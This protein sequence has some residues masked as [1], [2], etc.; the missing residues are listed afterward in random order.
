[1]LQGVY[2]YDRIHNV[3][4]EWAFGGGVLLLTAYM[5]LWWF[6]FR[7][8]LASKTLS[9]PQQYILIAGWVAAFVFNL[10]NPDSLLSLMLLFI[11]MAF[12]D[13]GST[14]LNERLLPVWIRLG[15]GVLLLSLAYTTL[16]IPTR[17]LKQLNQ[18]RTIPDLEQRFNLLETS[19]RQATIGKMEVADQAVTITLDVMQASDLPQDAKTF[20]YQKALTLW[21]GSMSATTSFDTISGAAGLLTVGS[22]RL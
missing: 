15:F 14:H 16:F 13:S 3:P 22:Q 8:L 2:W 6:L 18:Q 12:V 21:G 5:A 11:W 7:T 9:K 1:V 20:C 4:M 10:L 19:F 17:T